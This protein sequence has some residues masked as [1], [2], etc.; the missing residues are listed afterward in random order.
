M[1]ISPRILSAACLA[2]SCDKGRRLL[3]CIDIVRLIVV[4]A[5]WS[6]DGDH[7]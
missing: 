1:Y 4:S 2:S 7:H 3:F 6:D 5:E